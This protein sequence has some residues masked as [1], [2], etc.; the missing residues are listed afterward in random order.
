MTSGVDSLHGLRI[1]DVGC[2]GGLLCE[3][4][5]RL[6][7]IVTGID[8][9]EEAIE[10]AKTHAQS[11]GLSIDYRVADLKDLQ[12]APF[13]VVI[14]SEVIE[15]VEDPADF[16]KDI[17]GHLKKGGCTVIT[18]LN[19]TWKSLIL[20]IYVAENILRWAPKG[21]HEHEKF[22]KPSELHK[23]MEDAGLRMEKLQ[24][25]IFNPLKWQWELSKDMDINYFAFGV[26]K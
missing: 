5:T 18:T 6:G 4:L 9:S 10:V 15:H 11:H 21:A 25:L 23:L 13:D 1:L 2:G 8:L 16:V 17:A 14:A 24:G 20:G 19:R 12:D 3:P 22:I 7:A 26:K